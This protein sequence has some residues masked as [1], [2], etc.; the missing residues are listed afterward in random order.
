MNI[1]MF[2]L[3]STVTTDVNAYENAISEAETYELAKQIG[4]KALGYI[5]ALEALTGMLNRSDEAVQEFDEMVDYHHRNIYSTMIAKAFT[6]KQDE[7]VIKELMK[8]RD[9]V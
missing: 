2:K 7:Q 9:G 3:A 6:T 5:D 4:N 8:D 1:N